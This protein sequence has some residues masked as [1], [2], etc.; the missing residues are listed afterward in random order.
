MLK[1]ELKLPFV[2]YADINKQDR[3][4]KQNLT[5]EPF[6]LIAPH[7]R[8]LPFQIK[9]TK[10]VSPDTIIEWSIYNLSG[11]SVVDLLAYV[12]TIEEKHT[13]TEEYL[14][15]KGDV[16]SIGLAKGCYYARII[17]GS[18]VYYS[19]VFRAETDLSSFTKLSWWNSCDISP[20]MYQTGFVNTIYLDTYT[21]VIPPDI[22]EEGVEN[23]AGQFIPTIQRIVHKHKIETFGPDYLLDALSFMSIHGSVQLT[24][25]TDVTIIERV[26]VSPE[27]AEN[28]GGTCKIEFELPGAYIRTN[29]CTN[30]AL[31]D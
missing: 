18:D 20:V 26:K 7:D 30:I 29:C 1:T 22:N 11:V 13:A 24:E 16:L 8:L 14:T 3:F 5:K 10:P 27:F 25:G 28:Y 4:R 19:E 31:I 9:R 21:E 17:K 15:Y 23:G 2:W 12:A 6:A